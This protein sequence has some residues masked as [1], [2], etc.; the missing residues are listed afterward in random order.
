MCQ[1]EATGFRR[2]GGFSATGRRR[3]ARI[4]PR[5]CGT[6]PRMSV[7]LASSPGGTSRCGSG[8]DR[9]SSPRSAAARVWFQP[10]RSSAWTTSDRSSCS[11]SMPAAGSSTRSPRRTAPAA[12]KRE[13]AGGQRV[14]FGQQHRAL[15]GVAQLADV[16]RPAVAPAAASCASGATPRTLLLELGVV[17]V[18]VELDEPRDVVGAVAQRRQHNRQHVEPVEEVLAELAGLAPPPAGCGSSPPPRGRRRGCRPRRRR[19]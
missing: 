11:R 5:R 12:A 15:D 7:R 2:I 9:G 3:G 19:A 17:G 18:D 4:I 8:S 6:I 14:A 10:V 13:V 16:A 1:G